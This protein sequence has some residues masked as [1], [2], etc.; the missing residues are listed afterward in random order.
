[1][2]DAWTALELSDCDPN[3]F[4]QFRRWFDDAKGVMLERDAVSVATSTPDGKP[5][6]RMVL[7]RH[8]DDT[9][10]GWYT[11]YESRKGRE[12][13]ENP[14]AS[15]LWYCEPL[16]RQVR[17]EGSVEKMTATESDNYF[18]TRARGSQLGA[19]ASA[20]SRVI[21]SREELEERVRAFTKSSNLATYLAPN[22]G[23]AIA[24]HRIDSSS[25]NTVKTDCMIASS[26]C[27][28]RT[29][30][31]WRVRL[32]EFPVQRFS[33]FASREA[34]GDRRAARRSW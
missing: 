6:T 32:P 26:I 33:R 18:A 9:S 27:R 2:S 3:P 31:R 10:I 25:G 23:A 20:Q 22:S 19:H 34:R 4:V 8:V 28:R 21:V 12:L 29:V 24:S 1:M 16:G 15:I 7:L 5:S 11:N 13:E 17:I 30:G 14:Y